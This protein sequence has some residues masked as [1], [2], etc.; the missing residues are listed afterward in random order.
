MGS[1]LAFLI[2]GNRPSEKRDLTPILIAAVLMAGPAAGQELEPRAYSPSPVGT[3]FVI[4]SATRSAGGVFADPSAP[5]TDV[6]ATVGI[7]GATVGRTFGIAGKQAMILGVLPIVWGEASGAVGEDRRAVSR[8]GLGDP[9]VRLSVVLAGSPALSPEQ[10]MRRRRGT[11]FGAS[12]TVGP[13]L[14]QYD[15]AK[16]VNLGANR[17]SFK[18]E[19]GFAH[20]AGRWTIDGYL[21]AWFFT[22]NDEYYPGAVRRE[23]DPVLTLQGHLGYSL[24]R[25]AWV[26]L[27]A[28]WYTGGQSTVDGV[29]KADLLRNTRLGATWAMPFG[30]RNSLKVAYST[31]AATRVGADFRTISVA[32]QFVHF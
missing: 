15:P 3:T 31:G 7:L 10:F 8:R 12:L 13:S 4:V 17:W 26:A 16:L 27:N 25:R 22:D 24:G 21:G 29:L 14:G 11:T 1:D 18:P 32:W 9:R 19:I 6:E 30:P 28:T 2:A 20:P 5:I 23:Q